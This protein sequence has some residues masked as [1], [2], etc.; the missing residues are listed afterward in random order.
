MMKR[1]SQA[2]FG[3]ILFAGFT[4]AA[5]QISEEDLERN[6]YIGGMKISHKLILQEILEEKAVPVSSQSVLGI[7]SDVRPVT[8]GSEFDWAHLSLSLS[9]RDTHDEYVYKCI[10]WADAFESASITL[11]SRFDCRR[12]FVA[13]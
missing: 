2:V 7:L 5:N 1:L 3:I 11:F 6:T 12:S 8:F 10:F 13:Q 4:V 9:V